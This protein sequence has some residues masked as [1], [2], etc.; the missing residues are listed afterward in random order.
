MNLIRKIHSELAVFQHEN[1]VFFW[2]IWVVVWA[3]WTLIAGLGMT[4]HSFIFGALATVLSGYIVL[5]LCARRW[6]AL[7]V[8]VEAAD[9]AV[10][11]VCV[12]G[13]RT[14]QISDANYARILRSVDFDL[15]T[16]IVQVIRFVTRTWQAFSNLVIVGP[17]MFFWA[18]VAFWVSSPVEFASTVDSLKTVT[19]QDL[20]G[21][22]PSMVFLVSVFGLLYAL[23]AYVMRGDFRLS[24]FDETIASE[25]FQAIGC[26]A[27]GRV[28][29]L[30]FGVGGACDKFEVVN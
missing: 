14:G 2:A 27:T 10:W 15:R 23:V 26:P 11:I 6:K 9:Q 19:S 17:V 20:V 29:L 1:K 3:V 12:N 7:T 24:S 16:Y 18:T 21:A 28:T 5:W 22:M 13:I 30:Q 25:V 4:G 8:R